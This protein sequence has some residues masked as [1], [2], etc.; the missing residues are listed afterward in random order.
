MSATT[1]AADDSTEPER[2]DAEIEAIVDDVLNLCD[3]VFDLDFHV[4]SLHVAQ[5]DEPWCD[6]SAEVR[7]MLD[8]D[9]GTAKAEIINAVVESGVPLRLDDVCPGHEQLAFEITA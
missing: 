3:D 5:L 1:K 2:T 8:T 6:D 7:F 4:D 9:G